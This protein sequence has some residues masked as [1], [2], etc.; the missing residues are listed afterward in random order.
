MTCANGSTVLSS[1][2]AG[3]FLGRGPELLLRYH[4]RVARVPVV[5]WAHTIHRPP[6]AS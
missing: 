6:T 5:H 1:G 2:L 3:W 4:V